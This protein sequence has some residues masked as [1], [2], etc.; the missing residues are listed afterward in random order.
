MGLTKRQAEA[1]RQIIIEESRTA[2]KSQQDRHSIL[3]GLD[4]P[5]I[6]AEQAQVLANGVVNAIDD[7]ME[8]FVGNNRVYEGVEFDR[9]LARV[10][11]VQYLRRL[12]ENDVRQV[13]QMLHEGDFGME[14]ECSM[15]QDAM[16]SGGGV[17]SGMDQMDSG[18]GMQQ[19]DEVNLPPMHPRGREEKKVAMKPGRINAP[20]TGMKATLPEP[21]ADGG[22]PSDPGDDDVELPPMHP[23]GRR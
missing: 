10:R 21:K 15:D 2:A 9:G 4:E 7:L 19:D 8:S 3:S 22:Y 17:P 6:V 18:M 1:I 5:V 23:R 16:S 11:A 13:Q 14:D 20:P 12:V